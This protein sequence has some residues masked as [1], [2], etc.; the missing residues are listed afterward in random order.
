VGVRH[1]RHEGVFQKPE[2]GERLP[3]R[4]VARAVCLE[5]VGVVIPLGAVALAHALALYAETK[6]N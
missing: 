2:P 1:L 3:V 6:T 4:R 5:I